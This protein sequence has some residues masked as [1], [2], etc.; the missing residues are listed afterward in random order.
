MS[1]PRTTAKLSRKGLR[2]NG[3][4]YVP[5][6]IKGMYLGDT[7]TL[8]YDPTNLSAVYLVEHDWRV[9]EAAPGQGVGELTFRQLNTE[10]KEQRTRAGVECVAAIQ[11]VIERASQKGSRFQ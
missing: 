5:A 6:D 9:C 10:N 3:I 7:L 2:V 4:W 11:D 1:L 8:A